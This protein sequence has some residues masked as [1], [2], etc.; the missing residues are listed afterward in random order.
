MA[1]PTEWDRVKIHACQALHVHMK[2][3]GGRSLEDTWLFRRFLV[4]I[5]RVLRKA[6]AIGHEAEAVNVIQ[7]CIPPPGDSASD[8]EHMY[9]QVCASLF[10]LA[11][12]A[13]VHAGVALQLSALGGT[14]L[15]LDFNVDTTV[16]SVQCAWQEA[17]HSDREVEAC[18][19]LGTTSLPPRATM[20][21]ALMDYPGRLHDAVAPLSVVVCPVAPQ[22]RSHRQRQV[23]AVYCESCGMLIPEE[24]SE[25][26]A[27]SYHQQNVR[28]QEQ[29]RRAAEEDA[30]LRRGCLH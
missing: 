28:R 10:S 25:H 6:R 21:R 11:R 23:D 8:G 1:W 14:S 20:C 26:T 18:I 2:V 9:H 30:V 19:I 12:E 29:L 27:R 17:C 5:Q 24:L 4:L 22:V 15:I 3:A 7:S 13:G 16:S